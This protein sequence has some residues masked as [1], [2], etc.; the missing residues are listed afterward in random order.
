[1][2][3]TVD[4]IERRLA[5]LERRHHDDMLNIPDDQRVK[6]DRDEGLTRL[7][8]AAQND[9]PR[10]RDELESYK[11]Q[12][13]KHRDKVKEAVEAWKAKT[14]EHKATIEDGEAALAREQSI[15]DELGGGDP[16]PVGGTGQAHN[17]G[18]NVKEN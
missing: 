6:F 11:R 4:E 12:A 1:M 2:T 10:L 3:D 18:V 7:R 17:A 13:A 14:A 8:S 16:A 9:V 5:V 15:L